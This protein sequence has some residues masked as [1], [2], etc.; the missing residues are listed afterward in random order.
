MP[1]LTLLDVAK[2]NGNDAIVGLIEENLTFAPELSVITG[3]TI[4]GTTYRTSI[5]TSYPTVQFRHANEGV[6]PGKSTFTNKVVECY[7]LSSNIVVDKAVAEANEDG[8]DVTKAVE[9]SGVMKQALIELGSQIFYGRSVDAKGFP[10]LEATVDA[11]RTLDAGG[12]TAATGSSV[13]G[14][15]FGPQAVQ[16]I[17]GANAAFKLGDWREQLVDNIDSFVAAMN[18]WVGLQAVN[19]NGILRLKDA[20]ADSGK[21]VT[22][23]K[24]AEL[25]S[26][27]PVGNRPNV[28]FMNRRSLF[29]L[30]DSRSATTNN[31]SKPLQYAPIPTESNGIPI[32]VTDS[33]VSTEA[34]S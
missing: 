1:Q 4:K 6:T 2:L 24:L 17:Y 3:R 29:Q 15:Q 14:V 30:Q 5:R 12:T 8:P 11:A 31:D 25:L 20:T 34:L 28:W 13:Y 26:L 23:K 33:I 7:I 9:A 18:S 19:T 27:A 10:G 32:V 21:T 16:M 22:D